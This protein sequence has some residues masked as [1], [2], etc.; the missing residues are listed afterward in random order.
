MSEALEQQ[1]FWLS[2]NFAPVLEEQTITDLKVVGEIR[3]LKILSLASI[4]F[5]SSEI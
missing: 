1:P 5:C 3:S 2:G 4:L